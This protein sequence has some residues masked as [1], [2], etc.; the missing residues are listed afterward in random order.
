LIAKLGFSLVP[1]A[2]AGN[3]W[4]STADVGLPA[5]VLARAAVPIASMM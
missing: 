3:N 1:I 5:L 4:V 2:L